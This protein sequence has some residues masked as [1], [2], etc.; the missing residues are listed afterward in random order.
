MRNYVQCTQ[1]GEDYAQHT[2]CVQEDDKYHGQ[3]AKSKKGNKGNLRGSS[4]IK[5]GGTALKSKTEQ[6]N[7]HSV[8]DK[9]A[10]NGQI[11]EQKNKKKRKRDVDDQCPPSKKAKID[12]PTKNGEGE[13]SL[14]AL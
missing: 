3:W 9:A 8:K 14:V 7:G 5:N 11:K 13:C 6:P 1:F 4:P 10:S 12:T 2:S